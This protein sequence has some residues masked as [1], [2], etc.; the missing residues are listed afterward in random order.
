MRRRGR[1]DPRSHRPLYLQAADQ[2]REIIDELDPGQ[3]LPSEAQLS[4]E[5]DIGRTTIRR[6]IDVLT[7]EHLV[8]PDIGLGIRVREPQER[9]AF[10]P[11]SGTKII[12]RPATEAERDE[13]GLQLGDSVAV[14]D[15]PGGCKII[16]AYGI[17]IHIP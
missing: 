13:H 4:E 9:S 5:L 6:A 14:V 8:E 15:G 2:I 16:P 17:E 3:H 1:T 11:A 10:V 12:V 7:H